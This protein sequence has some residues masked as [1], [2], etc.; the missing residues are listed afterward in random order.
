MTLTFP[1]SSLD[2]SAAT[3]AFHFATKVL[4]ATPTSPSYLRSAFTVRP[5]PVTCKSLTVTGS[6]YNLFIQ[7][8]N[9]F[10]AKQK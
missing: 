6:A 7:W 4:A 1:S 3:R 10:K 8:S 9:Y 5:I 2:S